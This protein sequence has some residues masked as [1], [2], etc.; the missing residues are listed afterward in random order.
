MILYA[1]PALIVILHHMFYI[2]LFFG[3]WLIADAYNVLG[4]D[5]AGHSYVVTGYS[6]D[7]FYLYGLMY[8]TTGSS[9]GSHLHFEVNRLNRSAQP[10]DGQ[11]SLNPAQFFSNTNFIN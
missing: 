2:I 11:G 7:M 6:G 1:Y 3:Q 5:L 4:G 8:G 10:P 9:T